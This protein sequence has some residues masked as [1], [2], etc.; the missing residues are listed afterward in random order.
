MASQAFPSPPTPDSESAFS[1][2]VFEDEQTA[3]VLLAAL[4]ER[5][6]RTSE[7]LS[8]AGHELRNGLTSI[9]CYV[10]VLERNVYRQQDLCFGGQ[11]LQHTVEKQLSLLRD[12]KRQTHH[13][14]DFIYQLCT[15]A[16]V[17][18]GQV[19]LHYRHQ[20]NLIELVEQVVDEQ[21]YLSPHHRLIVQASKRPLLVSYDEL[22]IEHVLKNLLSNAVK[23]S[24]AGSRVV[25]GV[26]CRQGESQALEAVVWV[27]DEGHG[28]RPQDQE[29]VFDLFS[30]ARTQQG[31]QAKGMGIGLSISA[32]V[33]RQ[34]GGRIWLESEPGKGSTFSFSLPLQEPVREARETEACPPL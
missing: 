19:H 3:L 14:D 29:A 15:F 34:H 32:R 11:E 9:L 33:I 1:P 22:W 4:H 28:I 24:P 26:E 6:Q 27:Q 25:I 21:R 31:P 30:R 13:L 23:Y 7:F 8:I 18:H 20:A 16:Q 2:T 12:L 17:Q 10:Q 5:D